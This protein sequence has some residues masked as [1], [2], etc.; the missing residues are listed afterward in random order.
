MSPSF[1][2]ITPCFR[3]ADFLPRAHESLVNQIGNHTFEWIIVDDFSNDD[4][5]T[6]DA[7]KDLIAKSPL[8]IKSKY[9]EENHYGALSTYT[10]AL[11]AE[12][13]YGIIL[14]Q[15]D[16]LHKNA[17][18]IFEKHI[19]K[20]QAV[21]NFAGVCGRCQ[22]LDGTL[23]GTPSSVGEQLS[24]ELEIR[25]VQ[26]IRGEMFQCTKTGLL[27]DY[28]KGMKP[29]YTNGWAWSRIARKHQY[30]YTNEV[31]RIYDTLNPTSHT[32]TK[33]IKH[34]KTQFEQISIYIS[35]NLA[36]LNQDKLAYFKLC[37]Q[38][39][40]LGLHLGLGIK[41][42]FQSMPASAFPL[43][44]TSYPI[45]LIKSIKDLKTGRIKV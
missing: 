18:T 2:I 14:D 44:A 23:I 16:M 4:G 15:D 13:E 1:S 5:K 30:L 43:L 24:N 6:E 12:G 22:K 10:G 26:K 38:Y 39:V 32:N 8:I 36:Y 20:Y 37:A 17:L 21:P 11:L 40:R 45:G 33:H 34:I 27:I 31:V 25:H 19:R 28:F 35:D 42:I 9:L 41:T 7:I 3:G 29:G